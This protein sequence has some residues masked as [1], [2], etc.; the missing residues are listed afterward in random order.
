MDKLALYSKIIHE[1]HPHLI[2]QTARLYN[3]GGQ[4]N[5][6]IL[7]NESLLDEALVFRFPRYVEGIKTLQNEVMILG[8]LQDRLPLPIPNPIYT[9]FEEQTLAKNFMG[10]R[11]L[12]GKPLWRETL[13]AFDAL[14]LEHLA[15]Q[16]AEFLFTLHNLPVEWLAPGLPVSDQL[17]EWLALY[18]E[19]RQHLYPFMRPDA[20][21][22]IS[23]HFESYLNASELHDFKP[24]LRH[25]D[26]GSGNLLY[27]PDQRTLC[28]VID[29]GFAGVGDPAIDIAAVST[30]E[31]RLFS[32]FQTHYPEIAP[33]LA[34]AAFYKGTYALQ[35]ALHGLKNN[36][37]QAFQN[38]M[39]AYISPETF[40]KG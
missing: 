29:F 1:T 7:V 10:Y 18:A 34:R 28:G 17:D 3:T 5:D 31:H 6:L 12:P 2:I 13:A 24:A 14:T 11:R 22:T 27:D 39:A 30:L 33:L 15:G 26:F 35:E 23:R 19:F 21:D 9:H 36:D 40:T 8:Q 4:F 16:M 32:R 20:C 25:G 38:G 37:P